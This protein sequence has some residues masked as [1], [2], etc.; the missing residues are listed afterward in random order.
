MMDNIYNTMLPWDKHSL[1]ICP[2]SA[3]NDISYIEELYGNNIEVLILD[4]HIT[5]E[6]SK[7][8]GIYIHE[9]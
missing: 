2:D 3:S 8:E 7:Y 6:F 5:E 9:Y 1:V 4:H